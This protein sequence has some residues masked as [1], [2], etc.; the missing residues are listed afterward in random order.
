MP[1][2]LLTSSITCFAGS[3][4]REGRLHNYWYV[5]TLRIR[6]ALGLKKPH[7]RYDLAVP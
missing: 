5:C 4:T 2:K 3:R 1:Q 6:Q 7:C